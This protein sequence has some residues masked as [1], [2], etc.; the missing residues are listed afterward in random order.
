MYHKVDAQQSAGLTISEEKLEIQFKYLVEN[1]YQSHHLSHVRSLKQ[2]PSGKHVMITFD[3]GYVNQLIYAVP[4][5]QKYNLKATLFIPLKYVGDQD[6]WN[7]RPEP[8]MDVEMLKGLP[9]DTI[10]LAYHSYAHKKYDELSEAERIEDTKKALQAVSEMGL[11]LEK[12]V[13][14]PYGKFPRDK[15]GKQ[16]F[17][18]HLNDNGFHY[19]LRIGNRVNSFP[20]S[21]PYEINRIDVKGEWDLSKFKRKLRYGKWF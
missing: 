6:R 20:F 4:L 8:I 5:L 15:D 14:Y 19:G 18:Q 10:E 1:G 2:L 11:S 7:D 17:F 16:R 13:A 21:N 12:S 9:S 3:D